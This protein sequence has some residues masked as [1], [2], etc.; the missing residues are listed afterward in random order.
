MN[1]RF[2]HDDFD[3]SLLAERFDGAAH[4][5]A[6]ICSG[7]RGHVSTRHGASDRWDWGVTLRSLEVAQ[8]RHARLQ[9]LADS[10]TP[11]QRMAVWSDD[12]E[13]A[14]TLRRFCR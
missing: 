2:N 8:E 3:T 13:Q 7:L 4:H 1:L 6:V 9:A 12:S 11:D 10:L 5:H 14:R